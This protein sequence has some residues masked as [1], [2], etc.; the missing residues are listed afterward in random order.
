MAPKL[1]SLARALSKRGPNRVL[2]GNLAIAG[3]PGVVYTPE[4]G[5]NLPAVVFAHG[6]MNGVGHYAKTLE[7]LASWGIIVAAPNSERGPVPSHLGLATDLQSTLDICLGVRLGPGQLSVQANRV[8]FVGHGMGAGAA[9]I[10][11]TQREV[12]AVAALFPAPTAPKSEQYAPHVTS[13]GLI[14]AGEF[15]VDSMGCNATA[16]A[17]EWGGDAIFRTVDSALS[18]GLVEG[19]RLLGAMGAPNG[20]KK[21]QATTRALLTGFLLSTL[22]EDKTYSAFSEADAEIPNTTLV[23]PNEREVEEG[24]ELTSLLPKA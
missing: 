14:V 17:T 3:Q 13:P 12:Q 11:A 16:L 22:T 1:K 2:R 8:G 20:E 23:D 4:S 21:T 6:W 5:F 15:D 19:R 10:A 9:V 18:S 24:A 7:H